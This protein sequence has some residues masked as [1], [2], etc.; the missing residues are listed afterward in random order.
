M[1]RII[2]T[3]RAGVGRKTN[4]LLSAAKSGY[5]DLQRHLLTRTPLKEMDGLMRWARKLGVVPQDAAVLALL[6]EQNHK[7]TSPDLTQWLKP[8]LSAD[9]VRESV[10]RMR[11]FL[12]LRMGKQRMIGPD[13]VRLSGEFIRALRSGDPS[14]LVQLVPQGSAGILHYAATLMHHAPIDSEEIEV[15][16]DRL[17]EANENHPFLDYLNGI[18]VLDSL[19]SLLLLCTAADNYYANRPFETSRLLDVVRYP[20]QDLRDLRMQVVHKDFPPLVDGYVQWAHGGMATT[21]P[22]LEFTMLGITQL[23]PDLPDFLPGAQMLNTGAWFQPAVGTPKPLFLNPVLREAVE[24]LHALVK[25]GAYEAYVQS[26]ASGPKGL[27]VLA[28]GPPGTGKTL[29]LE[30]LALESGR[31]VHRLDASVVSKWVGETAQNVNALFRAYRDH[32]RVHGVYSIILANECDQILSARTEIQS[33]SDSEFNSING[34][35]LSC[36]DEFLSSHGGIFIATTN[37]LD[38]MDNAYLRRFTDTL[39]FTGMHPE[40]QHA[41][42][43]HLVPEL[44]PHEAEFLVEELGHLSP[45]LIGNLA[46]QWKRAVFLR[47]THPGGIVASLIQLSQRINS[48][49]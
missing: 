45:G 38:I 24:D 6:V 37:S 11:A 1:K 48:A 46:A 19:P 43:R 33:S 2:S 17:F 42:W 16:L 10:S 39:E 20:P 32:V 3:K 28:Y 13:E 41:L 30:N 15:Y 18:T 22:A 14:E 27:L 40:E 8:F 36:L 23:F 4:A 47:R 49:A 35:L 21:E 31:P 5:L 44:H 25:P 34:V 29:F 12:Y 7:M 26:I 9:E